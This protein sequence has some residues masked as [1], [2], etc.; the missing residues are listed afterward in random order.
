MS[1][2][3]ACLRIG[4][5]TFSARANAY[6]ASSSLITPAPV[7]TTQTSWCADTFIPRFVS[8][9]EI[10]HSAHTLAIG[11]RS[12]PLCFQLSD[13]SREHIASNHN[14]R[15]KH[16][17]LPKTKS[18]RVHLTFRSPSVVFQRSGW[19]RCVLCGV[20]SLQTSSME[21]PASHGQRPLA[22]E[23]PVSDRSGASVPRSTSCKKRSQVCG[24][25]KMLRLPADRRPAAV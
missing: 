4:R 23:Q 9:S 22:S 13:D 24:G 10:R 5:S 12:K 8:D 21:R 6:G 17:W 20:T 1:L 3:E 18:S 14:A 16:G 25:W 15:T 7:P 19:L 11:F 2:S